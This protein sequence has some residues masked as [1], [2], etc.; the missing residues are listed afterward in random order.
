[1]R[2]YRSQLLINRSNGSRHEHFLLFI[3]DS[4]SCNE[5]P[6]R[7][8]AVTVAW[9]KGFRF[10]KVTQV[11]A[12]C[13]PPSGQHDVFTHADA[14]PSSPKRMPWNAPFS[15][16]DKKQEGLQPEV[17]SPIDFSLASFGSRARQIP[18]NFDMSRSR[19]LIDTT[20][21]PGSPTRKMRM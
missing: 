7:R 16:H 20:R 17:C 18:T 15:S 8:R 6:I 12:L 2:P 5:K 3:Q 14:E 11:V 9:R 21:T 4:H 10:R 19:H 1:M 13:Y